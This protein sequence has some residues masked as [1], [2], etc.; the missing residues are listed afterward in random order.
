MRLGGTGGICRGGGLDRGDN[1]ALEMCQVE[2][3]ERNI[4]LEWSFHR[5]N[6]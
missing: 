1:S 5:G 4:K 3:M 6:S 2:M